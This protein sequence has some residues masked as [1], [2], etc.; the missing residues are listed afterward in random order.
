MSNV[1]LVY[2]NSGLPLFG[3]GVYACRR[4]AE[5]F[6]VTQKTVQ[7]IPSEVG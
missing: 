5:G 1:P 3:I 4:P 6:Q 2:H 7:R